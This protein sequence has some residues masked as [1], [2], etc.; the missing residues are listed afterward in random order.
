ML[1][2]QQDDSMLLETFI[3]TYGHGRDAVVE[4]WHSRKQV[5]KSSVGKYLD[6]ER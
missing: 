5:K 4:E 3:L 1:H 6:T 2:L